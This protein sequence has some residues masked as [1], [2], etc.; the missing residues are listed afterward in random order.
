MQRTCTFCAHSEGLLWQYIAASAVPPWLGSTLKC[1]QLCALKRAGISGPFFFLIS[2]NQLDNNDGLLTHQLTIGQG[3]ICQTPNNYYVVSLTKLFYQEHSVGT[4][5]RVK[6]LV[7][8]VDT[9]ITP[10][11]L[12]E[13]SSDAAVAFSRCTTAAN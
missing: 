6:T 11:F 9:M 10:L 5:D 3:A 4:W 12:V 1:V 8:G 2:F 7:G 13:P